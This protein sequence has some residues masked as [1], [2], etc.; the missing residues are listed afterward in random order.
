MQGQQPINPLLE[1]Y[2]PVVSGMAKIMGRNCE[3]LLHD[4]S[5]PEASVVACYNTHVTG[6]AVGAPMT[7]FGRRLMQSE[8]HSG[9]EGIYNYHAQTEDGRRLKCSVIFLRDKAGKLIGLI[10][11]NVDVSGIEQA[12]RF[13][14]EFLAASGETPAI[15]G[16]PGT[17][18]IVKGD[19][20]GTPQF[21]R[22]AF[23]RS[24]D[25]VWAHVRQEMRDFIGAPL[26]RLSPPEL[27][28]LIAKL[29]ADGFFLIKGSINFLAGEL[30]KSRYTIYGYLRNLRK[31]NKPPARSDN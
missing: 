30:G 27:Q 18:D 3:V 13:L 23:Y 8:E 5:I 11:V 21:Q 9:R 14:D 4:T 24:Q 2:L 29:E 12:Q 1:S 17:G 28:R 7:L 25:D 22:E 26:E 10:C 31:L 20:S 15:S 16:N 6:R 19:F